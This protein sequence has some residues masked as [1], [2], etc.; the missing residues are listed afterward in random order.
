MLLSIRIFVTA[1]LEDLTEFRTDSQFR[2]LRATVGTRSEGPDPS[3]NFGD[4]S[5]LQNNR[6]LSDRQ[7]KVEHTAR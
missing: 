7:T 1:W 3:P 6:L 2:A 5:R 4:S